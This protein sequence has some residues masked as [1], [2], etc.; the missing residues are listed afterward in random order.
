MDEFSL[1]TQISLES[2]AIKSM[3]EFQTDSGP[4]IQVIV[5]INIWAILPEDKILN[6]YENAFSNAIKN[7]IVADDHTC[8]DCR[9]VVKPNNN[10]GQS[11]C[12]WE[13][14]D[15]ILTEVNWDDECASYPRDGSNRYNIQITYNLFIYNIITYFVLYH[16]KRI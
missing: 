10:N 4:K 16:A 12:L 2:S 3:R 5:N 8:K 13:F 1:N 6:A 9:L 11:I 15:E 14:F 7:E